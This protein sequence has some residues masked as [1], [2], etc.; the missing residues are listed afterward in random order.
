MRSLDENSEKT[1][2][3]G[4]TPLNGLERAFLLHDRLWRTQHV[5]IGAGFRFA[6]AA[7]TLAEFRDEMQPRLAAWPILA[8]RLSDTGPPRWVAVPT[9]AIGEQVR[10]FACPPGTGLREAAEHIMAAPLPRHRPLWEL[11]LVHDGSADRWFGV[12]KAHHALFDGASVAALAQHLLCPVMAPA[13]VSAGATPVAAPEQSGRLALVKG[14]TRYVGRLLPLARPAFRKSIGK[15]NR[16]FAWTWVDRQS[17]H[18]TARKHG[19]TVNDIFLAALATALREWSD[20]PWRRGRPCRVW[21]LVPVDLRPREGGVRLGNSVASLRV[22]LPCDEPDPVRRLTTIAAHTHHAENADQIAVG[23]AIQRSLPA[24]LIAGVALSLFSPWQISLVASNIRGP[25]HPLSCNGRIVS[26]PIGLGPLAPGHPLG[27]YLVNSHDQIGIC[28]VTDE[29]TPNGQE[30][31]DLWIR[32]F[33]ELS[34][35]PTSRIS[36]HATAKTPAHP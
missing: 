12:L 31:A 6:G 23:S 21:T 20:T 14:V 10:E 30:L 8:T 28:V 25:E 16:L 29:A 3:D 36:G 34:D 33:A 17:V 9:T 32:A 27:A 11:W 26:D 19:V 24:W 15:G 2:I 5:Q 18:D 1:P 35:L 13:K 7:P 4:A 22:P